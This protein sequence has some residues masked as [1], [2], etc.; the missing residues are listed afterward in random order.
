[1]K[2]FTRPSGRKPKSPSLKVSVG[3]NGGT[4]FVDVTVQG[5]AEPEPLRGMVLI[6]FKDVP[7]PRVPKA[8][9]KADR[10]SVQSARVA[11]LAQELQHSRDE[12]Q[13]TREEMQ[14]SQEELKSANEELH[15]PTRNYKAP[16]RS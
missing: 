12:V 5:L 7:A 3:T 15:P 11:A 1:M 14:T 2:R 9:G 6:V 16:T 8:S 10:A 13:T 4:Q